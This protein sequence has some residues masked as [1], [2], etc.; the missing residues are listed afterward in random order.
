M[1]ES[2]SV[3]LSLSHSRHLPLLTSALRHPES[4]CTCSS[5]SF[6][7]PHSWQDLLSLLHIRGNQASWLDLSKVAKP[8]RSTEFKPRALE[9]AD[10]LVY[11][12]LFHVQP[13]LCSDPASVFDT[14]TGLS[15]LVRLHACLVNAPENRGTP[16]AQGKQVDGGSS[17][18]RPARRSP[19]SHHH[20][21]VR[22]TQRPWPSL[23]PP[24]DGLLPQL[25]HELKHEQR[26]L[27]Y[28]LYPGNPGRTSAWTILRGILEAVRWDSER[29]PGC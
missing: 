3:S 28:R 25:L 2:V 10:A 22:R 11:D 1:S 9:P 18:A 27:R 5:C 13:P 7:Q 16:P 29:P 12:H 4:L 26:C 24:A 23:P 19:V 17:K 20:N 15:N 21:C 6:T 8:S 14:G